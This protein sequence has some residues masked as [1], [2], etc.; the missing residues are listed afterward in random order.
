M[1][2]LHSSGD[3][4]LSGNVC[5]SFQIP[6]AISV[7][8]PGILSKLVRPKSEEHHLN[9]FGKLLSGSTGP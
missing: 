7:F 3:P 4:V 6:K 1:L 2:L 9:G 5:F 8:P